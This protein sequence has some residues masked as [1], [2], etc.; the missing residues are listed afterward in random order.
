MGLTQK[1]NSRIRRVVGAAASCVRGGVTGDCAQV[2]ESMQSGIKDSMSV[3]LPKNSG[4]K[5]HVSL[6]MLHICDSGVLCITSLCVSAAC[7][8]VLLI[9]TDF[10]GV[11][12]KKKTKQKGIRIR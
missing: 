7:S 4:I 6:K 9:F 10:P 1:L 11:L 5:C 8:L 12:F 2:E 3:S